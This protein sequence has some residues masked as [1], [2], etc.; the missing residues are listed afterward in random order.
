MDL[1]ELADLLVEVGSRYVSSHFFNLVRN[2]CV[3]APRCA[4]AD[5]TQQP[6]EFSRGRDSSTTNEERRL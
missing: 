1:H 3:I 5:V 2:I 4:P 6:E